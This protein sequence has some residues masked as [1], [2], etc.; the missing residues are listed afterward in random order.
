MRGPLGR[1]A[2]RLARAGVLEQYVEHGKQVQRSPDGR[3]ACF[4]RRVVRNAGYVQA[5]RFLRARPARKSQARYAGPRLFKNYE[6]RNTV[7]SKTRPLRITDRQAFLLERTRPPPVLFANHESRNTAFFCQIPVICTE[8]RIPQ[9]NA[10]GIIDSHSCPFVVNESM[11]GKEH[12]LDCVD[13][14]A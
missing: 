7:F 2:R 8:S 3:M 6:T 5:A 12:V 14:P 10:H 11:P 13:N 9:E 4:D 1:G